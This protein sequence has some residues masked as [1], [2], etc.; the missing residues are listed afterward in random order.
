MVAGGNGTGANGFVG[1]EEC[2]GFD[3]RI[4]EE[5]G[6]PVPKGDEEEKAPGI[7]AKSH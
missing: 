2:M 3:E 6:N 7:R 5:T 4:E 1:M